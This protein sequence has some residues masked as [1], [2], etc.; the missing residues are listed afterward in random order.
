[1][2]LGRL[3]EAD[4]VMQELIGQWD[5][6]AAGYVWEILR[7]EAVGREGRLEMRLRLSAAASSG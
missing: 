7:L 3:S 6:R 1:M 5:G 2:N 4:R